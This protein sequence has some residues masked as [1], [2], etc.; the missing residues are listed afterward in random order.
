MDQVKKV[1]VGLSE[2]G[3]LNKKKK[4][5]MFVGYFTKSELLDGVNDDIWKKCVLILQYD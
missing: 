4:N 3:E 1:C 5:D 2:N